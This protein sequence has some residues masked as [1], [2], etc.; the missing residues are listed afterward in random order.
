MNAEQSFCAVCC[1]STNVC[2]LA[3]HF[4]FP[5]DMLSVLDMVEVNP[6]LTDIAGGELTAN[7]ASKIILSCLGSRIV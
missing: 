3:Y 4:L 6:E 5:V 2:L 1:L 7:C